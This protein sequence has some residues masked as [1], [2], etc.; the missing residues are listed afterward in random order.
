MSGTP[1]A[2]HEGCSSH[3]RFQTRLCPGS[4]RALGP[5]LALARWGSSCWGL[6][7]HLQRCRGV[8]WLYGGGGAQTRVPGRGQELLGRLSVRTGVWAVSR[9]AWLRV[10]CCTRP[11]SP[12]GLRAAAWAC[13][14]PRA[15]RPLC[16]PVWQQWGR[17]L[18]KRTRAQSWARGHGMAPPRGGPRRWTLRGRR[19]HTN[20]RGAR[21]CTTDLT[22][23]HKGSSG[24]SELQAHHP[25]GR[26]PGSLDRP[27]TAQRAG[28]HVSCWD[29]VRFVT[30]SM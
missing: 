10:G 30:W 16:V 21:P 7:A 22:A 23:E 12:A 2:P 1:Q 20:K 15:P 4:W 5:A 8:L 17:G 9:G 26:G 29:C 18:Q 3:K 19:H 27:C 11:P 25:W 24:Q 14:P 28:W 6:G 13:P